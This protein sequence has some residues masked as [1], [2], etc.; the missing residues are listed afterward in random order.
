MIINTLFSNKVGLQHIFLGIQVSPQDWSYIFY[1]KCLREIKFSY[2]WLL[3]VYVL[4]ASRTCPDGDKVTGWERNLQGSSSPRGCPRGKVTRRE[5]NLQGSSSPLG[6][7]EGPVC[8]FPPPVSLVLGFLLIF[9]N[10]IYSNKAS[11][12]KFKPFWKCSWLLWLRTQP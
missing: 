2:I 8:S 4:G 3:H 6:C 7:P 10:I 12:E 9:G 11:L 1:Q 5:R